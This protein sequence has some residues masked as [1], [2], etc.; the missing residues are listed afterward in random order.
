MTELVVDIS[1]GQVLFK[2]AHK[3]TGKF[4]YGGVLV[5][6]WI[7]FI[8]TSACWSNQL[9]WIWPNWITSLRANE[10]PLDRERE[11]GSGSWLGQILIANSQFELA[12]SSFYYVLVCWCTP[13]K[14]RL[15][16][17]SRARTNR[18]GLHPWRSD[19]FNLNNCLNRAFRFGWLSFCFF[20]ER[21]MYDA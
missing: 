15:L 9:R 19:T 7:I 12:V 20:R 1:R 6:E 21:G 5:I 3:R 14:T 8:R 11:R 4:F 17:V 18:S 13:L 2:I 16:R 10:A